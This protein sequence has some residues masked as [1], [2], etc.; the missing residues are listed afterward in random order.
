[1]FGSNIL[2]IVMGVVFVYLLLSLVCSAINELISRMLSMRAKNL[3]EGIRNLL[4][5]P[6]GK[7]YAKDFFDHPL[8]KSLG[9]KKKNPSYIP[10]RTFALVLMDIIAPSDSETS[11][12][13]IKEMKETAGKITNT[14]V[15]KS[16]LVFL[17]AAEGNIQK[18][19]ENIESWFDDA[20]DRVSGWYK[21]KIQLIILILA[22]GV[23]VFLNADTFM[24]ANSLSRDDAVRAAVIA[25]AEEAVKKP[26]EEDSEISIEKIKNIQNELSQLPLPLGWS[27]ETGDLRRFPKTFKV[28]IIK[29]LGLLFTAFAVSMGAP[30][31][32]DV[33][34]KL[35][36]LRSAGGKPEKQEARGKK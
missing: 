1:M 5:D 21:R 18:V 10:S 23:T 17:N 29:I 2:E 26:I 4:D 31:W 32:F 22:L 16:L 6:E 24:I 27:Q 33:L 14:R 3:E 11:S 12:L 8:V 7:G 30:F 13:S 34:S 9:R 25:A 20:M 15:K 36:N 28:W 35:V 19:R